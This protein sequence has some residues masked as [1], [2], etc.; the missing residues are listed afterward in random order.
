MV[1][2]LLVVA[3]GAGVAAAQQPQKQAKKA[4]D[5]PKAPPASAVIPPT[6]ADYRYGPHARNTF[7]FWQAKSDAPTPLVLIIHGGGWVN[8]DKS[9]TS[10]AAVKSY[11][12]AGISVAAL[13]YRFIKHGMEE[14]VERPV[15]APL[16]DAARALQTLR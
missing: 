1:R 6:A 4:Q 7:D 14:K 13:N 5:K 8:G 11:L 9:G 12:D 16:Y 2:S 15:K 3:L 10:A